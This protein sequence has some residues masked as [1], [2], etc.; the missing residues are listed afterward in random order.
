MSDNER[1]KDRRERKRE[2][3]RAEREREEGAVFI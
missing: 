2:G 1:E 3:D